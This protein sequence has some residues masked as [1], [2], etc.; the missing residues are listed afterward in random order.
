M[1]L[2]GG[3]L[4]GSKNMQGSNGSGQ[5]SVAGSAANGVNWL[6]DGGDNNDA[7]SNVNLPVPFPDAVQ[8]FNVQ[9]N[10][11]PAQ[12][13]LHAGGVVNIVTKSGTNAF[14]G[15]VFEF[16]RN[17]D[18]NA[19]QKGVINL[20]PVRDSLK[21][22]QFGG[23]IGGPV[24]KDKI[25][26][27]FGYQGTRQ[28]SDPAQ[29]TAYVPTAAAL[30]G[31]FSVLDSAKSA[32]GCLAT[33]KTLK[34]PGGN[35]Y[36]GNQIPVS[37]FDPAGKKLA[38][39]FVP[40]SPNPCGQFVF[41]FLANNPDDQWIGR[42][43]YNISNKHL[44]FGRYYIYDFTAQS[45]FDGHNALTTGTPGNQDRSQ[46]MTIGDT[47]TVSP[48]MINAFHATFD[49]RR[50][51][52]GSAANLFSPT[53]LGVNMF[54]NAPNYTQLTLSG[55]SGGGFNVGCGT[56]ALANFDI[57]TYQVADDFTWIRGKHQFAFGFDGR[58]DQ[59]N[60]YNY[61]QANG[62][63]TFNGSTTGDG[64]A[65]LL[66]GRFSGLTDGNVI[67]DYLR[68]T[69]IAAYAQDAFH[70]TPHL[71]INIG[72]RWE[73]SV[74]AYDKQG[75]GNQFSWPLFLQGWHSQVY[76]QAPAGL[77][78]AG[79]PEN[80]Y[81]KAMTAAHWG[82]FSPRIGMVWDP[83]G[84]GKQTIRSSF[85]LIHETTELF[86]PERWTTN[87]PYVSSLT[88]TS[89]QFSNPFA[90]YTLNGKTGD[91]FPG[92]AVFPLQGAY[93]SIPGNNQVTYMMQW[94]LSYQ[95][96]IHSNW[97][98]T[99]NYL[100]NAGRHIWG[101]VDVNYAMNAP[102]ASTGNT[103]NRRLTYLI[104]PTLGQYYG[105]IQQ[106]DDGA[107]S[108]Y[109]AGLLT[110]EHQF[111]HGYTLRANYTYSHCT[112]T[113]DFAGELAGTIYQ[114]PLNRAQ[115]ERG[116]CGYDHRQTFIA[117]IVAQSSGLGTGITKRLTTD[118]QLSPIISANTGHPLQL[119][120][121]KDISLSGQNQDRPQVVDPAL[122]HS[123]TANDPS[124]WFNPAAFQCAG[125]NAACTVFSGQFG[126][127][128]RNAVYGPGQFNWDMAI[129]RRF[130][131]KERMKLDV[132]A[133]FFN[134]LNHA[135]ADVPTT[136]L[137]SGTFGEITKFLSPRIIQMALKLYF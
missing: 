20:Q 127:L 88:L 121:G 124:Y 55:Y 78:F 119:T 76:P 85:V 91:P 129:S 109:H 23:T 93:I 82:T 101:S 60:S 13:G 84:N 134:I 37:T 14:H 6:L 105:D 57:N 21:R 99:A 89:G 36:P 94:N 12:Y 27:F 136:A 97:V 68:Q 83:K 45:L 118:W 113:W 112:S 66:V 41:G 39:T 98:V 117:T 137:S 58:K 11:L 4:T 19:R 33:A 106:T 51:N 40:T 122:V 111:S 25:F 52:R 16:L 131:M 43:D 74:P 49:R 32:G 28:R 1:Q 81:G 96:Q 69:V 9:T 48:T 53:D 29:Q 70:A 107:N 7:F 24:R 34:D 47:Y 17:G 50:D 116:N 22:N 115:G 61:Q 79:D 56:C 31:D 100:G 92:I 54:I 95:R 18:L 126:N 26:F 102:G 2:N 132:R 75:R 114:N 123:V 64:L 108:S 10:G 104:N 86:Y 128:G 8:E 120:D 46:T 15:N 73:P 125:S 62:Q 72:G 65:D 42:V 35:P 30:N 103:N 63:F 3:D 38:T 130:A 77:I 133:D 110:V 71:S 135:N 87:A 80:K 5:Y 59:F 90:N 44:F 67:S